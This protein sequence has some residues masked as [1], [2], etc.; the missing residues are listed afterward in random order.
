MS[1]TTS[2]VVTLSCISGFAKNYISWKLWIELTVTKFMTM[3]AFL[4]SVFTTIN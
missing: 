3:D 4:E 1:K 2:H